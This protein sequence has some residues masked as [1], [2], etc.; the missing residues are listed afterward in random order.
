M[1]LLTRSSSSVLLIFKDGEK[2]YETHSHGFVVSC[3]GC[4]GLQAGVKLIDIVCEAH[5]Y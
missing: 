4:N 1:R 5:S 2:I 3:T